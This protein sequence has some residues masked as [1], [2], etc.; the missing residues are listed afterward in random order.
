ML[1]TD[2]GYWIALFADADECH[3]RAA[4]LW[5]SLSKE[6]L[7][8]SEHC[9]GEVFTFLASRFGHHQAKEKCLGLLADKR[10]TIV[11]AAVSDFH[12]AIETASKFNVS[13]ADAITARLMENDGV[14]QLVSFDAD[15]DKFP[16]IKRVH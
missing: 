16:K 9:L 8:L 3:A 12:P 15:F 1:Y 10:M 4:E 14:K 13:F 6:S 2:S 7:Q 11:Q 5:P